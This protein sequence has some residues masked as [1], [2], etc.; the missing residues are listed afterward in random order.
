[1]M[2]SRTELIDRA[3]TAQAGEQL[4]VLSPYSPEEA[5]AI[6]EA[7]ALCMPMGYIM[8]LLTCSPRQFTI[9]EIRAVTVLH[10]GLEVEHD[11]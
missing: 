6:I 3:R 11:R 1:M 7:I 9:K 5:T 10:G 4:A 8:G 2:A